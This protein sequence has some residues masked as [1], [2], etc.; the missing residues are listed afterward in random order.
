MSGESLLV[1]DHI[2]WVKLLQR[3][4]GTDLCANPRAAVVRRERIVEVSQ[5]G[6][7]RAIS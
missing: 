2:M 3:V 6:V 1:L 7:L 4:G 5:A